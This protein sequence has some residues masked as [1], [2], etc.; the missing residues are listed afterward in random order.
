MPSSLPSQEVDGRVLFWKV[1]LNSQA[2]GDVE[3]RAPPSR[4]SYLIHYELFI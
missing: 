4:A 2:E 1:Y 3:V